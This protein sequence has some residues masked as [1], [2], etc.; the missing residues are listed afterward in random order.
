MKKKKTVE[1]NCALCGEYKVMSFEHVP[2]K[3]AFNN[4]P[5]FVQGQ[6]HLTDQSNSLYGKKMRSNKG[7]GGYTLC[8][9]C[10]NQTGA[11]YARDFVNFAHQ[12]M[13]IIQTTGPQKIIQGHYKIKPLNVIKQI[14]VM[15]MSADKGGYLRSQKGL[16]EFLMNKESV[17]MPDKYG[18]YMYST[19]SAKKRMLG[20]SIFCDPKRGVQ[21]WSEINFE[22]FGY[23]L[24]EDSQPAHYQMCD[25]T[26]FSKVSYDEELSV[27]IS[28]AYLNVESPFIGDYR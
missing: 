11:W 12:G 2:P 20:Y 13:K 26:S 19:L 15:F 3:A 18:V 14:L 6:V 22:P 17:K 16:V 27:Q 9:A 5:I 28:T 23:F 25:I 7:F 8:E 10:N 21:K 1:D 4:E 24:T